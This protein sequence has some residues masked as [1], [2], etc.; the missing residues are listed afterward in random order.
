MAAS[1][2]LTVPHALGKQ[3][4]MRRV[5]NAFDQAKERFG[6]VVA[7]SEAEWVESRFV[8]VAKA[9]SQSVR[10]VAEINDANAR[11]Q[12]D[13]PLLLRPFATRLEA[14]LVRKGA[15]VLARGS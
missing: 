5:Q 11:L 8:F 7:F 2:D 13:L 15:A 4:A 10:G 14:F 1:L 6:H 12:V 3:K 9:M